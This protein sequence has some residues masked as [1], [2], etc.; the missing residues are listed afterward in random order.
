M[1]YGRDGGCCS[2]RSLG[3]GDAAH[4]RKGIPDLPDAVLLVFNHLTR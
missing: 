1:E 2:V 4:E 3:I